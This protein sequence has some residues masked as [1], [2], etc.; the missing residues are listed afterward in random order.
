MGIIQR[1][2]LDMTGIASPEA[3]DLPRESDY[4]HPFLIPYR[5]A[6]NKALLRG[7]KLLDRPSILRGASLLHTYICMPSDRHMGRT[8]LLH[9]PSSAYANGERK[10]DQVL[11]MLKAIARS[12]AAMPARDRPLIDIMPHLFI[13]NRDKRSA[14]HAANRADRISNA[15]GRFR[16]LLPVPECFMRRYARIFIIDDVSTTGH[17]LHALSSLLASAYPGIADRISTLSIAH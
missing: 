8:L 10:T 6:E 11:A 7:I 16:I 14:Q 9:A 17:T 4:R 12:S 5:I 3:A 1:A 2:D 15:R 13:L